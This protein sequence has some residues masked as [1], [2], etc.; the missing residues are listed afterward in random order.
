MNKLTLI[1]FLF[2]FV[3]TSVN[4]QWI[5]YGETTTSEYFY[6]D[7]SVQLHSELMRVWLKINFKKPQNSV[8]G[9]KELTFEKPT[10]SWD[11]YDEM[12][13]KTYE[14]RNL[15]FTLWT[16]RDLKGD[17]NYHSKIPSPMKPTPKNT[18]A[19]ILFNLLC[20]KKTQ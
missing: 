9:M 8:Y 1:T 17:V 6:A 15:F 5:K 7:D 11:S 16:E 3:S 13:C 19:M 14:S 18:D 12:N 4:A 20:N 2:L 10:K